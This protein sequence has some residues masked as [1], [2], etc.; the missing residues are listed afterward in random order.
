[1]TVVSQGPP[2]QTPHSEGG[3]HLHPLSKTGWR[4]QHSAPCCCKTLVMQGPYEKFLQKTTSCSCVQH[5]MLAPSQ[6]HTRTHTLAL[7]TNKQ[8]NMGW[9][10]VSTFCECM[11]A[12]IHDQEAQLDRDSRK[13]CMLKPQVPLVAKR[14]HQTLKGAQAVSARS[15]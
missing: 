11:H 1:M 12:Y 3:P 5:R 2:C 4:T 8:P 15:I 14:G 10:A 7:V 9:S 13:D 6:T